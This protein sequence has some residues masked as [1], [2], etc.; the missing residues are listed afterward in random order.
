MAELEKKIKEKN[1]Q[2]KKAFDEQQKLDRYAKRRIEQIQRKVK[3]QQTKNMIAKEIQEKVQV[4]K[5]IVDEA[6][7]RKNFQAESKASYEA[8]LNMYDES[9]IGTVEY[10]QQGGDMFTVAHTENGPIIEV[11][12]QSNCF[13]NDKYLSSKV[14][15]SQDLYAV[16]TTY[17]GFFPVN[18]KGKQ[19]MKYGRLTAKYYDAGLNPA[20]KTYSTLEAV[21][22]NGREFEYVEHGE[23]GFI[24]AQYQDKDGLKAG[25][26]WLEAEMDKALEKSGVQRPREVPKMTDKEPTKADFG[27][28]GKA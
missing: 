2:N 5:D 16:C 28:M 3:F 19:V 26:K 14:K 11:S 1:K 25:F 17:E 9:K 24:N 23:D 21:V 12:R 20:E 22:K 13:G 7:A 8:F 18:E 15:Q 10:A 27:A 6:R 4:V